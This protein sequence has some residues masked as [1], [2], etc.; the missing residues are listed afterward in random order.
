MPAGLVK[1]PS[2]YTL[3]ISGEPDSIYSGVVTVTAEN[4]FGISI[5]AEVSIDIEPA[6]EFHGSSGGCIGNMNVVVMAI[7]AL[8]VLRKR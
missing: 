6:S 8:F 3:V 7:A 4:E 5:P 1:I 2:S